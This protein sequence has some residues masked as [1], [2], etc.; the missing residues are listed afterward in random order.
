MVGK[1]VYIKVDGGIG[2]VICATGAVSKFAKKNP[3]I[4]VSV[5]TSH[6]G[7]FYGVP[8][9]SRVYQLDQEYLYEDYVSKGELLEPEPYNDVLYYRDN[10]HICNV[11]NKELNGVDEYVAPVVV[12][13]DNELSDAKTFI[14]GVRNEHK[15]KVLLIQPFG[16]QGGVQQPD[17][18]IKVDESY[19]SFGKGF[20]RKFIEYFEKDY[21]ILSVQST[22][23][24]NNQQVPQAQMKGTIVVNNPD[25]KK[26]I[27]LIPFVDG[28]VACDS[29][30][31]HASAALQSPTPTVVLWGAT[32][33]ANLSYSEHLNLLSHKK[34]EFEPN[35]FPHNHNYYVEANKNCN[36][37]KED[38]LP[39]I[40]EWVEN[41]NSNKKV[42]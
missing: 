23:F 5:C 12:L 19:R 30:L 26:I 20:L 9:V 28:V 34:V 16:S 40:K 27:A 25:I 33:S 36:D 41:G 18:N 7:L 8:G 31:H 37:F 22:A 32:N 21:T 14:E 39:K 2:R 3:D 4:K 10:K 42:E 13:S 29:F 1:E 35:R 6:K 17:G 11:F 24:S 38:L 15:K